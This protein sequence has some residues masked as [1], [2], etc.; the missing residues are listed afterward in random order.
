MRH[1][2]ARLIDELHLAILP[3]VPLP[4][5]FYASREWSPLSGD[6]REIVND[7]CGL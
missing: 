5:S 3:V 2:R 7:R 4:T 6:E 1:R